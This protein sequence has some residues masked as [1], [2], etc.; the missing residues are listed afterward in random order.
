MFWAS[1]LIDSGTQY[2]AFG[3]EIEV[4]KLVLLLKIGISSNV[5]RLKTRS[6]G[7]G[8]CLLI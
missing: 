3:P 4:Q 2:L 7:S 6:C 8:V 5:N 1:Y